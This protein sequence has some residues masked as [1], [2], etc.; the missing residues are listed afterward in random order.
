MGEEDVKEFSCGKLGV[1]EEMEPLTLLNYEKGRNREKELES[2]T[3]K[4]VTS[5]NR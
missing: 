3:L 1:P 4:F 5:I 2:S